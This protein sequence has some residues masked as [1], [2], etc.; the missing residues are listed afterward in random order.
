[1]QK[2]QNINQR[3][4]VFHPWCKSKN[5]HGRKVLVGLVGKGYIYVGISQSFVGF[6]TRRPSSD[7]KKTE[8]VQPKSP[9][10]FSIKQGRSIALVRSL[11]ALKFAQQC[12]Q[13]SEKKLKSM[14]DRKYLMVIPIPETCEKNSD[15]NKLFVDTL[16]TK[17]GSIRQYK[18]KELKEEVVIA[19]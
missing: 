18:K 6:K 8:W 7:A 2:T 14:M 15:I 13:D 9:D 5:N 17:Y 4:L 12:T 10:Q 11:S 16:V 19:H 3:P 1:M